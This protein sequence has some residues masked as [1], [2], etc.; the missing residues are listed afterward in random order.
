MEERKD[1]IVDKLKVESK[2]VFEHSRTT[3][4]SKAEELEH[5]HPLVSNHLYSIS[6]QIERNEEDFFIILGDGIDIGM[7]EALE[8]W[9]KLPPDRVMF[10]FDIERITNTYDK[11]SRAPSEDIIKLFE[12]G[13]NAC[14]RGDYDIGINILNQV[15]ARDQRNFQTLLLLG[16]AHLVSREDKKFALRFWERAVSNL[17]LQ[18]T[19]HYKVFVLSLLAKAHELTGNFVNSL[20]TL[21]RLSYYELDLPSTHYNIARNNALLGR[22]DDC[23]LVLQETIREHPHYIAYAIADAG[24]DAVHEKAIELLEEKSKSWVN[25]TSQ[26]VEELEQMEVLSHDDSFMVRERNIG[27]LI[28]VLDRTREIARTNS[29]SSSMILMDQ[30]IPQLV[31]SLPNQVIDTLT[32]LYD[33]KSEEAQ[34][35]AV[36]YEEA[37]LSS[38]QKKVL[39]L[40]ISGVVGVFLVLGAL[41]LAGVN[42]MMSFIVWGFLVLIGFGSITI[43]ET[44]GNKKLLSFRNRKPSILKE[45][46]STLEDAKNLR[47]QINQQI[48]TYNQL[49]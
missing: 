8:L 17:P 38:K 10:R 44:R 27:Q 26:I 49:R 42:P 14:D 5:D 48:E 22:E 40:I 46:K 31:P 1:T 47:S 37:E 30:Y 6:T 36:A 33:I 43:Y 3:L 32:E 9:E 19:D 34:Q 2:K 21:K 35:L 7:R 41:L 4:R 28:R 25:L 23:I 11:L 13:E 24:F 18:H 15:V 20:M 16:Y 12:Q 39:K 29:L 45:L